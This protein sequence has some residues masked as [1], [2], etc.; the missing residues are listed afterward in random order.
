MGTN[1]RAARTPNQDATRPT[2]PKTHRLAVGT[3]FA[4]H[5]V[6]DR[7]VFSS[8]LPERSDGLFVEDP[9]LEATRFVV[10]SVVVMMLVV[11]AATAGAVL[12][13]AFVEFAFDAVESVFSKF[14]VFRNRAGGCSAHCSIRR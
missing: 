8:R 5:V 14:N 9:L 11:L 10:V 3:S 6:A 1:A 12:V 7:I 4:S 2:C 13:A